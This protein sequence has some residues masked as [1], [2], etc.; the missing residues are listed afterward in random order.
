[1][2]KCF[3]DEP[4]RT[5]PPQISLV[6]SLSVFSVHCWP[7]AP[8]IIMQRLSIHVQPFQG[9]A[10]GGRTIL[11]AEEGLWLVE[12]GLLAVDYLPPPPS[13]SS[14]LTADADATTAGRDP[15]THSAASNTVGGSD[16]FPKADARLEAA[17]SPGRGGHA[18]TEG[19]FSDGSLASECSQDIGR[20]G[21]S[22]EHSGAVVSGVG[23]LVKV[24]ESGSLF[25]PTGLLRETLV[26]ARVPWECYRAYAELKRRCVVRD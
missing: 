23:G 11:H 24:V 18:L 4:E 5:S 25:V 15:P 20:Q 16:G 10:W 3:E 1:M 19:R 26:R 7:R 6:I 8:A 9:S 22:L 17:G 21:Q 13:P 14:T 2:F 12:R